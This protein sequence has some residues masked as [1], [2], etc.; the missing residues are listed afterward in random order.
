[1]TAPA[2]TGEMNATNAEVSS[3]LDT[4]SSRPWPWKD[5]TPTRALYRLP[6]VTQATGFYPEA[7]NSQHQ[8]ANGLYAN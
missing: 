4:T 6:S 5:E 3:T 1:V 8:R 7:P 2:S